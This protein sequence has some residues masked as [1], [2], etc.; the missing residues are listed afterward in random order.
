[1]KRTAPLPD[2]P[3]RNQGPYKASDSCLEGIPL[4]AAFLCLKRAAGTVEA[5][6]VQGGRPGGGRWA[7]PCGR[8]GRTWSVSGY[9]SRGGGTGGPAGRLRMETRQRGAGPCPQAGWRMR[10][11]QTLLNRRLA[12]R[13]VGLSPL[14]TGHPQICTQNYTQGPKSAIK[15]FVEANMSS[16][17]QKPLTNRVGGLSLNCYKKGVLPSLSTSYPQTG[18]NSCFLQQ[19]TRF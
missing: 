17:C 3:V 19:L 7:G 9:G 4:Q 1:M 5:E 14:S 6:L 2:D 16:P 8:T 15:G 18:E 13:G 12:G 10:R 11:R